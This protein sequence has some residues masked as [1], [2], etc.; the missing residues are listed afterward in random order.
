MKAKRLGK[1]Y[2]A[3]DMKRMRA[4]ARQG[5]SAREAADKLGRTRAAV[6]YKAMVERIPF[7]SVKQPAGVQKR[8]TQR[9][10]LSRIATRRHAAERAAA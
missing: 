9:R 7:R 10:T 1:E 8:R 5:M 6:A 2:T 4:M 3:H